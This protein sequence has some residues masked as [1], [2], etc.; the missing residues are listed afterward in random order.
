M[1]SAFFFFFLFFFPIYLVALPQG[2]EYSVIIGH[3]RKMGAIKNN[4]LQKACEQ[5]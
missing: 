2:L 1:T 5:K 4:F 3:I